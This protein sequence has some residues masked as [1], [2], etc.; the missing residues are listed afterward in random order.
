MNRI[1]K[2]ILP[3]FGVITLF[4]CSYGRN[5]ESSMESDSTSVEISVDP[6][7]LSDVDEEIEEA[8]VSDRLD[9]SFD[10]FL[11]AFTHSD[12]LQSKRIVW[13]LAYTDADGETKKISSLNCVSEFRFLKGDSYT[14][15]Y[16]DRK[17]IEM[18]KSDSQ[19]SMVI[20]ERIDLTDEKLRS[21]E[22]RLLAGKWKLTS[23]RDIVFHESDIYDF[24][25]FYARFC[26]DTLYQQAHVEQP[27]RVMVLDPEE[28]DTY[29]EGTINA[30]QWRSFCPDVP[31][32][33]ISNIRYGVQIYN[34]RQMIL[35]KSGSSNGLQ[36]LF[37]F[38]K[39][40][41]EWYLV[42]YEN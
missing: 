11:F 21:F 24:L 34:S 29:I 7:T 28:D 23:M 27:L 17:Q 41:N 4:S 33:I 36:E 42:R 18:Q 15:M 19:D 30:E 14:V 12:R 26:S 2:V 31:Q 8:D 37:F 35:Q 6:D 25:T 10:D 39:E 32:G 1:V 38:T 9:T 3:L 20:V 22:F 13:P 5:S 16:G 40:D